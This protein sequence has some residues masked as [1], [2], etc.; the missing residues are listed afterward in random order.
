M[1]ISFLLDLTLNE[2]LS[3]KNITL[4]MNNSCS[5]NGSN[6]DLFMATCLTK[7]GAWWFVFNLSALLPPILVIECIG[8]LNLLFRSLNH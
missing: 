7:S 4:D 2:Y 6:K 8:K 1:L 3:L 5:L